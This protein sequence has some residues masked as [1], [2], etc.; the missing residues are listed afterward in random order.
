MKKVATEEG[1]SP[2]VTITAEGGTFWTTD[3]D[4]YMKVV[5]VSLTPVAEQT[6]VSV[7][8]ELPGATL[9]AK[10]ME[11]AARWMKEGS[12]DLKA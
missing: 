11:K 5:T 2:R 7:L 8:I 12:R 3:F 6:R 10:D 9:S 4:K 1:P